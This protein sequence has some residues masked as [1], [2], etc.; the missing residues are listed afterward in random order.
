MKER[1]VRR[2][3]YLE[4]LHRSIYSL[5][6]SQSNHPTFS[7]GHH[8]AN[9]FRFHKIH[10]QPST[11]LLPHS[12]MAKAFLASVLTMENCVT[13]ECSQDCVICQERC[14]TLS[15]ETGIMELEVRLPCDHTAGSAVSRPFIPSVIGYANDENY[16]ASQ[17]G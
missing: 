16:S 7:L 9:L 6:I 10:L 4:N 3:L 13:L 17:T 5:D 15:P 2:K 11:E 14:G 12:P 8:T 1:I